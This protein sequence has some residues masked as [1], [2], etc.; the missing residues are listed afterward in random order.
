MLHNFCRLTSLHMLWSYT[1]LKTCKLPLKEI[2]IISNWAYHEILSHMR[3]LAHRV[4]GFEP[5]KLISLWTWSQTFCLEK[6]AEEDGEVHRKQKLNIMVSVLRDTKIGWRKIPNG[7]DC[8]MISHAISLFLSPPRCIWMYFVWTTQTQ[9]KQQP[10]TE[11]T[12]NL[13][14][15]STNF[16]H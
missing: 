7:Y 15:N 6:F 2:I 3:T 14:G 10:W 11:V 9:C 5:E 4:P 13:K 8:N 12:S 1:H 16:T